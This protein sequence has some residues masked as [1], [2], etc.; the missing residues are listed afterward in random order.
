MTGSRRTLVLVVLIS[1][2]A[3]ACGAS[4]TAWAQVEAPP[5][6]ALKAAYYDA[7]FKVPRPALG[8]RAEPTAEIVVDYIGFP[9]EAQRAFQ[10]AVDIWETHI[11]S[12]VPIYMVAQ[13]EELDAGVLGSTGATYIFNNEELSRAPHGFVESPLPSDDVWY[14]SA[15]ATAIVGERLT[16]AGIECGPGTDLP[17]V[18]GECPDMVARFNSAFDWSYELDPEPVQIRGQH[19]LT[20]VVLHEI[21]HGLG[22]VDSFGYDDGI[23][24]ASNPD[25]CE[26]VGSGFACW[27]YDY[28]GIT[29]PFAFDL[30][31]EDGDEV[32]L[33]NTAIYPNPSRAL[34]D[35]LQVTAAELAAGEGVYFAGQAVSRANVD[36]P[37]DLYAPGNFEPGSSTAHFDE[38]VFNN[39][40]NALMTPQLAQAEVILSPGPLTCA[41]F[42]DIGWPLGPDCAQHVN[43]DLIAFGAEA[44]AGEAALAWE[45]AADTSF[46]RFVVERSRL[47]E[48]GYRACEGEAERL[49]FVPVDT[50]EVTPGETR[51]TRV[52]DPAPL[53]GRY[54]V[55][56]QL[57]RGGCDRRGEP[58]AGD[59]VVDAIDLFV[60]EE[61]VFP[62]EE[63]VV[64]SVYP[65]PFVERA[66]INL[67]LDAAEGTCGGEAGEEVDVR[68]YNSLGRFVAHL[69]DGC[70]LEGQPVRIDFPATQL[71]AGVYFIRVDGESFA[72]T[73][74]AVKL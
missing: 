53:P 62:V 57:C 65:N 51:Y 35:A 42:Y 9:A 18:Q 14:V 45:V 31:V 27:G 16:T 36:V 68:V 49:D 41:L 52:V 11:R 44:V 55:Q 70:L 50:V 46:T 26:D 72:E 73:R 34:G 4:G 69:F 19:H 64:T 59:I 74:E 29:M 71:A 23:T 25:E 30:F 60:Q 21:G 6:R 43:L 1:L 61:L 63:T 10:Y 7:L 47:A 48:C 32:S 17:V 56:L 22:F 13:W 39:T 24:S 66:E 54:A 67:V 58:G 3:A 20:T 40:P 12:S 37:A 2:V 28:A 15:L 5:P 38:T 8:K 33:L